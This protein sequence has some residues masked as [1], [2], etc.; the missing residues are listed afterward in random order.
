MSPLWIRPWTLFHF[1]KIFRKTYFYAP[2]FTYLDQLTLRFSGP[3]PQRWF[4]NVH[5]KPYLNSQSIYS[6]SKNNLFLPKDIPS[7]NKAVKQA[8]KLVCKITN[9]ISYLSGK[10]CRGYSK[11]PSQWEGQFEQQKQM[12]K[13]MDKK[14]FEIS[15]QSVFFFQNA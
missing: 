5:S 13:L 9:S 14:L 3:C 1:V 11:E 6:N 2:N 7:W 15:I 4:C 8:S 12:L 10:I